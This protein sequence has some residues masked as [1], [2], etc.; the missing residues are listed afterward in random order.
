M[1]KEGLIMMWRNVA[2][3]GILTVLISGTYFVYSRELTSGN[4]LTIE[5]NAIEKHCSWYEPG[6]AQY[7]TCLSSLLNQKESE[8]ESSIASLKREIEAKI[9]DDKVN[10]PDSGVWMS[11][12]SFLKNLSD[13][14][15]KWREYR[16]IL[17][18]TKVAT[19]YGGSGQDD[20][21][22]ECR[23]EETQA[24]LSQVISFRGEWLGD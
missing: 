13:L 10:Y 9:A 22:S 16:N 5:Q 6:G 15:S 8:A 14:D 19:A 21:R 23:I 17:C 11:K 18:E 4:A 2:I 24:Y 12:V 7:R 20:Q 3:L 1:G